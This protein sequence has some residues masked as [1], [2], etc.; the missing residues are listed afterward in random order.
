[1]T[2]EDLF[3]YATRYAAKSVRAGK[4]TRYPTFREV[5]KRFGVPHDDIEQAC[6]DWDQ[7]K[8]YMKPGVGFASSGGYAVFSHRGEHLVEAYV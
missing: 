8:G 6:E 7:S 2:P 4:G 3:G 5:S 1:M